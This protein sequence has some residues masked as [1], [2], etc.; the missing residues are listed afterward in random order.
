MTDDLEWYRAAL[1]GKK[2][3]ITSEPECGYYKRKLARGGPWVP[4]RIFREPSGE[5]ACIVN[6][7]LCDVLD[8]WLWLCTQP[9]TE[10]EYQFR[11]ATGKWATEYAPGSPEANPERKVNLRRLPPLFSK[12]EK[13]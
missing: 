11:V 2:P 3:A 10:R 13:L 12:K 9:I 8:E 7:K 5:L 1:A 6:G 4:G